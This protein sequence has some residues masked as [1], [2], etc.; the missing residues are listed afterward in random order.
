MINKWFPRKSRDLFECFCCPK[1]DEPGFIL[2]TPL[3]C[4][5]QFNNIYSVV[6]EFSNALLLKTTTQ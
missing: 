5:L 6:Y 4:I 2:Y 3:V 1:N